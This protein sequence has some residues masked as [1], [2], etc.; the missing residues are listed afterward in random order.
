VGYAY[1][2]RPPTTRVVDT[3]FAEPG[4]PRPVGPLMPRDIGLS[5]YRLA[6]LWHTAQFVPAADAAAA[7]RLYLGG[8]ISPVTA[9]EAA[10]L[11]AAGYGA[12]LSALPDPVTEFVLEVV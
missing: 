12:Y 3:P 4:V 6:G 11:V 7:D 10:D 8:H 9:D 1:L 2:F 5:V